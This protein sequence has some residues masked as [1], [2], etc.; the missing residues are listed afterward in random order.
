MMQTSPEPSTRPSSTPKPK[1]GREHPPP[2]ETHP[3]LDVI[4]PDTTKKNP[5]QTKNRLFVYTQRG[6]GSSSLPLC[7]REIPNASSGAA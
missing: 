1:R 4:N 5:K 2:P 7:V 6:N 3:V